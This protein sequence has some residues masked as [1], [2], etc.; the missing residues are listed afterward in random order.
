[1]AIADDKEKINNN[2]FIY[3]DKFSRNG[4]LNMMNER[5]QL[6]KQLLKEN[7]VIFVSIDDNEQAYLKILM[8]EI[9]GE[10]NFIATIKWNKTK[11][12]SGNTNNSKNLLDIQ[13]EFIHCYSKNIK[14]ISLNVKN[15]SE[16]ELKNS[17]YIKKDEFFETRGYYALTPLWRSN[18]GSSFQYVE[19]LDY[20]LIA[21][22]GTE[23]GIWRNNNKS[24]NKKMSY[25]W[26]YETFKEGEKLGFIEYVKEYGGWSVYRKMYTKVKF[27]TKT[28][29]IEEIPSFSRYIDYFNG[30]TTDDAARVLNSIGINFSFSKPWELIY[31]LVNLHKNKN[32]VEQ[33]LKDV[34][35]M[36]KDFG[37]N[38][39]I[40]SVEKLL[41]KLRSLK[42]LE[43]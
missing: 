38:D 29:Q 36:L 9:F 2:K 22:D 43:N 26:S 40:E 28:R 21:P 24:N 20:K 23:F 6:A 4:W 18:S 15:K 33:L 17:G 14:L 13:H 10:D 41:P 1:N 7:G 11:K 12:P 42:P 5:L 30:A 19:S 35:Q 34:Q 32:A 37:V 25:T 3:R 8:D 31:H 39:K 27:N 16:E